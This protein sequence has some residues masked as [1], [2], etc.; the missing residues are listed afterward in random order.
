MTNPEKTGPTADSLA[1]LVFVNAVI[2]GPN[3]YVSGL[4]DKLKSDPSYI[5]AVKRGFAPIF[6]GDP[7]VLSAIS[8]GAALALDI[9][10]N[11][12]YLDGSTI[13]ALSI[14]IREAFQG[15]ERGSL[16]NNQGEIFKLDCIGMVADKGLK[17]N[18]EFAAMIERLKMKINPDE[19]LSD[20]IEKGYGF[21]LGCVEPAKSIV[22]NAELKV[23]TSSNQ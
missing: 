22:I 4:H 14:A 19:F 15:I 5:E 13:I 17:D 23:M 10:V 12:R 6:I 9:L 3:R 21:V 18:P 1:N 20:Y 8:G 11:Q 16:S 7:E 2:S